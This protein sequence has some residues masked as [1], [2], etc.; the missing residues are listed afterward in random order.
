MIELAYD[1]VSG[2]NF[3]FNTAIIGEM[4]GLHRGR[5]F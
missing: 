5:Y 4:V 3:K 2:A 1:I